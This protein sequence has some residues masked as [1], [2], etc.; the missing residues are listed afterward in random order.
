MLARQSVYAW[1]TANK[2]EVAFCN[3]SCNHPYI[4]SSDTSYGIAS[5]HCSYCMDVIFET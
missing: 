3:I 5:N 1:L 2:Y 4:S